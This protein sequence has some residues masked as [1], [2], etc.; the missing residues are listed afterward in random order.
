MHRISEAASRQIFSFTHRYK[1][2]PLRSPPELDERLCA[3]LR[4]TMLEEGSAGFQPALRRH[5]AAKD[6]RVIMPTVPL[7]SANVAGKIPA[8]A[9]WKPVL[10]VA[11]PPRHRCR[12]VRP[13]SQTTSAA[14]RNPVSCVR[15]HRRFTETPYKC[16]FEI[17]VGTRIASLIP[18]SSFLSAGT[19]VASAPRSCTFRF[20]MK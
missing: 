9:G 1:F 17:A 18:C 6:A 4:D 7:T 15:R 2:W 16:S 10:P 11:V 13:G 3:S 19:I 14:L 20:S 8:T 12:Q 5:L